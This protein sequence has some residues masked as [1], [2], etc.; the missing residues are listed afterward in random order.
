MKKIISAENAPKAIGPY[1]QGVE[2]N[3]F[4]FFSGQIPL[5]PQTMQM[6]EGDITV[7][8]EQ[9]LQNVEAVLAGADCKFS[10]V[11]K[12][13]MFLANMDDFAKA[14]EVYAKYFTDNQP[15]RSTV[16]VAKLPLG[17]LVEVECVAVKGS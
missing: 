13:T 6:V 3:G 2:A 15:A 7:Q 17:A 12:T 9:V 4:V 8:A 16:Q 1:S 14:N 10:N 11:I 5:D